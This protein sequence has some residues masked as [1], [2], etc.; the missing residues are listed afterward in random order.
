MSTGRVI[1]INGSSSSGKTSIAL[2]LQKLLEPQPLLLSIDAFL[3]MLPPVGHLG[4]SWAERTNEN[5]A[6]ENAPLRWVFPD[7]PGGPV[8]IE[9]SEAGHRL[10]RG[11]HRAIAALAQT[12]NDVIFEHV[13]LEPEW[14]AD[15]RDALA[16]VD[17]T[18]VGVR[19]PLDVIEERERVRGNRVLGQGRGHYDVVHDGAIYDIEV[20]TNEI[21][22]RQAARRIAAHFDEPS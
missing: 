18:F 8:R 7:E 21:S 3:A 9:V 22:P 20:N 2:E 5:G 14:Q 12:G 11:M 15:L 16:A 17:V 10:V 19:C 13:F 1:I 6:V 4:M